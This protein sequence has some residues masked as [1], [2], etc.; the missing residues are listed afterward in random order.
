M[1][2]VTYSDKIKKLDREY[3]VKTVLD[4]GNKK[5][6]SSIFDEGKLISSQVSDIDF[7][8]YLQSSANYVLKFHKKYVDD[9]NTILDLVK[10]VENGYSRPEIAEKLGDVLYRKKM[11]REGQ[12]LLSSAIEKYPDNSK[13]KVILGKIFLA[14]ELIAEA[15]TELTEAVKISPSFPDYRNLLGLVYLKAQKAMAAI[16][17]FKK[18]IELNIYYYNAHFNLG[19]GY[20]LNGIIKENYEL[21]KGLEQNCK[22][23]FNNAITYNP[24]LKTKEYEQAIKLLEAGKLEDAYDLL[25]A[26]TNKENNEPLDEILSELYLNYA[27]EI[28]NKTEDKIRRYIEKL[29]NL[30]KDNPNYADLQNELGKAYVMLGKFMKDKAITHFKKALEINPAYSIAEKNL[31]LSENDMRGFDVFLKAITR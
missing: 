20:V 15:E 1:S 16:N 3:L 21:A 13:L 8:G 18:A 7:N 10:E 9:H 29:N 24:S 31:K 5:I 30:L 12:E 19:L 6:I 28:N 22:E 4:E 17:Q 14:Q 23:T 25:I 2:G 27:L 11:Y 26:Q